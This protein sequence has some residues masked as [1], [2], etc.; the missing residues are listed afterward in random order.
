MAATLNDAIEVER[1][2]PELDQPARERTIYEL[3][4]AG[5][6]SDAARDQAIAGLRPSHHWW[7]WA[8]RGLLFVG[9]ALVLSGIVF[10]F[11][12]NWT[13]MSSVAKFGAVEVGL[14]ICAIGA[15][16]KGLD[17]LSGKVLLLAASVFVGVLMAVFGQVYQTGAD[18]WQNY[19][20]WAALILPWVAI[21]RFGALW[22]LWLT[23]ADAALIL[24]WNQF[25]PPDSFGF[26]YGLFLLLAALNGAALA[27][28]EHGA[29]RG[30]VW[31]EGRWMRWLVWISILVWLTIPAVVFLVEPNWGDGTLAGL[32]ALAAVLP[33]GYFYYRRAGDLACVAFAVMAACV[34]LLTLI[35]KIVFEVSDDAPAF[36]LFGLIVLGV[37]SAAAFYLRNLAKAMHHAKRG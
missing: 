10:F 13:R 2:S 8:N 25:E 9:A 27:G 26:F 6:L 17:Q 31:L 30:W 12:Y 23:V 32:V 24:F 15:V 37:S 18:A 16:R 33:A 3:H 22:V 35:G 34:V 4:A 5:L 28:Y 1:R 20:L 11:A 14:W 19:A 7:H 36:L 29:A 21:G